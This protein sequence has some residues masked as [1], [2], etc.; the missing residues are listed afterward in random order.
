MVFGVSI[1]QFLTRNETI[2]PKFTSIQ[3]NFIGNFN[4]FNDTSG[5]NLNISGNLQCNS[6][7]IIK[8]C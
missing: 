5:F 4:I 8:F 2:L 6:T 7:I 1:P 3:F